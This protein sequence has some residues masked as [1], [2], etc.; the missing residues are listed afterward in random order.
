MA[1]FT[2]FLAHFSYFGGYFKRQGCCVCRI[3]DYGRWETAGRKIFSSKELKY[4]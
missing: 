4:T 2:Y 3:R 1:H